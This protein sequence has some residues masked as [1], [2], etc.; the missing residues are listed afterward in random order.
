[1][2]GTERI[3]MCKQNWFLSVSLFSITVLSISDLNVIQIK[4]IVIWKIMGK[5]Q[6]I[7]QT[8]KDNIMFKKNSN[9]TTMPYP[10]T[11]TQK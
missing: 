8:S 3:A 10:G 9:Q 5:V 7:K 2:Q 6:S 1:M 4:N 11:S